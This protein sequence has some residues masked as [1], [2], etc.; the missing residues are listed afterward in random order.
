MTTPREHGRGHKEI[1]RT[2]ARLRRALAGCF[3]FGGLLLIYSL[4]GSFAAS[5]DC[6]PHVYGAVKLLKQG[7]FTF[8]PE[9]DP[10]MFVW[11]LILPDGKTSDL[12]F[13]K[14]DSQ[15]S[16]LYR[17]G[18]L[19]VLE[20]MYFI[21]PSVREGR[22]VN[23]FGIGPAISALP[24]FAV[25]YAATNGNLEDC[26]AVLWYGAKFVSSALVAGS[27]VLVFLI[28]LLFTSTR[29]ALLISL[30]YGLGTCV[31]SVSSQSLWQHGPNVFYLALGTYGLVRSGERRSYSILCGAAYG[32]AVLC[33]PD[34]ALVV[35]VVGVHLAAFQHKSLLP[36]IAGGLPFALGLAFYNWHF[37]GSP[38]AFGQTELAKHLSL[39]KTGMPGVWQTP[40]MVG[41]PG[42]LFSPSRGLLVY[43]PVLIIAVWGTWV[44]WRDRRWVIL[45]PLSIAILAV[46]IIQAKYFDWWSGWSYGY[47]HIVDTTVFMAVLF[48]PVID[49][50]MINRVLLAVLG[51]T[52]ALSVLIQVL[53]VTAY[54]LADWNAR[55][56]YIIVLPSGQGSRTVLDK[57]EAGQL[58]ETPGAVLVNTVAMDIDQPEYRYRL[59]SW[60]DSQIIYTLTHWSESRRARIAN[61]QRWIKE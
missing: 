23:T 48:L 33:R 14:W 32:M 19:R 7:S 59:W 17:N 26:P 4:D 16:N 22:Y 8:T 41:L 30:I 20:S 6:T 58:L 53:G 36:F 38:L 35:L 47:R 39:S 40:L 12:C 42:L 57:A 51:L 45:R 15:T 54:A 24:V 21:V 31:W 55:R 1:T 52:T 29:K 44:A 34:S 25:L 61:V 37:L 13:K 49:R 28:G 46:W 5:N 18:Q 56:A 50:I 2:P 11:Q 43:S 60:R 27:A 3:L 10:R 9:Q